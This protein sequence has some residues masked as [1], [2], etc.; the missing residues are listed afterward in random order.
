M[1]AP[2]KFQFDTDFGRGGRGSALFEY[3][4]QR[5]VYVEERHDDAFFAHGDKARYTGD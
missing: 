2:A 3:G 1:A 4:R 5:V